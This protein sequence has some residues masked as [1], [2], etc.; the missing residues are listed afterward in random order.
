MR[1]G[2]RL[3]FAI[4]IPSLALLGLLGLVVS[5]DIRAVQDLRTFSETVDLVD[6]QVEVRAALQVERHV[7]TT[8]ARPTDFAMTQS[9]IDEALRTLGFVGGSQFTDDL[10]VARQF[11]DNN[12]RTQAV[13]LY[14]ELIS[15]LDEDIN[16][17]LHTAPLGF[18]TQ[19][20][21]AL[22]A[23][24]TAQESLVLENLETRQPRVDPIR[25]TELHTTATSNL[26]L[27]SENGSQSG[28]L[29]LELLTVSEFWRELN[30]IRLNS[31]SSAAMGSGFDR[32]AWNAAADVRSSELTSLISSEIDTLREDTTI[33]VSNE[34]RRLGLLAAIALIVIAV[35]LF[36]AF[37]LRRSIVTPLTTL[38]GNAR[39]LSRG[40]PATTEDQ[41]E[42]EIGEM[43]RA[44][45]SISATMEHL[46]TD[47]DTVA[48]ALKQG[49]YDKRI[50]TEGLP[51]DWLRLAETLNSTLATGEEHRGIVREELDRRSVM[52]EISSAAALATTAPQLT[53]AVLRHLPSALAGSH[54]HLHVHPSG[55]PTVDLG[56]PLEPSISALEMPTIGDGG[57]LVQ[58]RK[59]VG[60]ACLV[61]FPEG[62]PAVLVLAFGKTEPTQVEPLISLLETAAQILAQAHRRQAAESRALHDREHDLLT[63]LPNS[64]FTRH[65]FVEQA[66]R[67]ITWSTIGVQPQRLDEL[68]GRMGRARRDLVMKSIADALAEVIAKMAPNGE[69][70]TV[71]TRLTKPDFAIITPTR[72]SADL[73][74][75]FA[76]RFDQ[77]FIVDGTAVE[78]GATITYAE[79]S[80]FDDDLS[81]SI[82]NVTA[83]LAQAEGRETE[84][85]RFEEGHRESLRRR[86]IIGDWLSHALENGDLSVHF[87]P[88]VN[89]ITTSIEG[90]EVLL[91]ATMHGDPIS[92]AEVIPIAEDNGMITEIGHF[93]LREACAALPLLRGNTPYVAVNL[94]PVQLSDID[95]LDGIERVLTET[96]A[97][98][99]RIIFEVTEGATATPQG[100]AVLH[101]IRAL[102]VKIAIDDFGSGQSNLAYLNNLPAQILKLDRSL[103]TP[104]THDPGAVTLVQK[105]IEMAHALDMTVIGEG[106]ETH[107]ELNALRRVFCDRVQGWFTGRPGPLE[108]F[109]EIKVDRTTIEVPVEDDR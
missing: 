43:S 12:R 60:V 44:F 19:R 48:T 3:L 76:A 35:A 18:T 97:P 96:N 8:S 13:L 52:A 102:G 42:D 75:A 105:T 45:A 94:S 54:T 101:E 46:W 66:D 99:D 64:E 4:A 17:T 74:T 84:V 33:A 93:A 83:A 79:V 81:Q 14:T 73:I 1:I 10:E 107:E 62:P 87:Q 47:V 30:L 5:S 9:D 16:A 25:L 59:G 91:R 98:R 7:G 85:I 70:E 104:M 49:E 63:D 71:L 37:H 23:L 89:T 57:K 106:V 68:D 26:S 21:A 24:L 39:R 31:F 15:E 77:P 65:W 27:F 29:R 80:T 56:I 72:T 95:L 51:G 50:D 28:V 61:E 41:A 100:L 11:A 67:S 69:F 20:S 22:R 92:P 53:A 34:F 109:M 6:Q 82:T 32:D 2:P 58:L 55:P 108:N 78:L 90:Y 38:T 88:I 36:I 86:G 103:V 40:E